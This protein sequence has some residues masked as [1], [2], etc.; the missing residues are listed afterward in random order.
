MRSQV[1]L[2]AS[3]LLLIPNLATAEPAASAVPLAPFFACATAAAEVGPARSEPVPTPLN[4]CSAHKNCGRAT[5]CSSVS[6]I[7]H[8]SCSIGASS[9][10]C[11]GVTTNCPSSCVA[12]QG[13]TDPD[14]FCECINGGGFCAACGMANC[15]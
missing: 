2:L 10:T 1:V 11:D 8:I 3:A 15:T 5:G 6:C 7:G 14:G 12:P 4:H 13:C 9:V